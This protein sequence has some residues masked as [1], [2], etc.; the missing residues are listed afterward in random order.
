MRINEGRSVTRPVARDIIA[1]IVAGRTQNVTPCAPKKYRRFA[2]TLRASSGVT[3]LD[4]LCVLYKNIF[5]S[6]CRLPA[7]SEC[8]LVLHIAYQML[9]HLEHGIQMTTCRVMIQMT[10]MMLPTFNCSHTELLLSASHLSCCLR[11]LLTDRKRALK[12]GE[13]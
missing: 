13:R 1:G 12:R 7:Q 9:Q 6:Y 4:R 8:L 2:E 3:S 10:M 11:Q 5:L